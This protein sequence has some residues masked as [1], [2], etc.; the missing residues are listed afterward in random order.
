M[1]QPDD[2]SR[3]HGCCSRHNVGYRKVSINVLRT[4]LSEYLQGT[5]PGDSLH[6]CEGGLL[7][8]IASMGFITVED[9]MIVR[10]L[11][12]LLDE[13]S[14]SID[15]VETY[16]SQ[17]TNSHS[18]AKKFTA[19]Y[20]DLLAK[21]EKSTFTLSLRL[22][23]AE[24]IAK[25]LFHSTFFNEFMS[26]S[27]ELLPFTHLCHMGFPDATPTCCSHLAAQRLCRAEERAKKKKK[28]QMPEMPVE[29]NHPSHTID[30]YPFFLSQAKLNLEVESTSPL[31]I[32]V[33]TCDGVDG[34][35]SPE[36]TSKQSEQVG[37]FKRRNRTHLAQT[38][39]RHRQNLAQE[40]F[41]SVSF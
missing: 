7:H 29:Y 36:T 18:N 1:S 30:R 23:Q 33:T 20:K 26:S 32:D 25:R 14:F 37:G 34:I 11:R 24:K 3:P 12:G 19:S 10:T 27:D 15:L 16:E 31:S 5:I 9:M 8:K 21:A 13:L 4:L 41:V 28:K 17:Q 39:N 22:E 38:S 2:D 40:S 6:L 35:K